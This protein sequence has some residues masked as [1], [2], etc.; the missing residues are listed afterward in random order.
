[1]QCKGDHKVKS[2]SIKF[3]CQMPKLSAGQVVGHEVKSTFH[4]P[5]EGEEL[6]VEI[7]TGPSGTL[8]VAIGSTVYIYK[9]A[10]ILGRIE[11]SV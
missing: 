6:H 4:Q 5:A 8:T 10:D 2:K 1:M 3:Y 7:N 11:V 9:L